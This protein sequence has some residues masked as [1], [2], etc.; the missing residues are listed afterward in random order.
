MT[1]EW[2]GVV[3]A[4]I[5]GVGAGGGPAAF[6]ANAIFAPQG[7]HVHGSSIVECPNGDLLACWFHGS[8][9][10]TATDVLVQGAR[11]RKGA[12]EWSPVF[13]MADSPGFPDC[14]P[15]LFIDKQDRLWLFWIQVLAGRWECA[16]L[17]YRRADVY[18]DDG[19]PQWNWQDAIFLKPGEAFAETMKAR[20]DEMGLEEGMWAEYALPYSRMLVEAAR[21]DRKR[22]LGWMT[23][24]HPLELASGRILLPLYSDGFNACLMAVTDDMGETWRASKPIIGLGPIQPSLVQRKNGDVVAYLRDSGALP[25]RIQVSESQDDGESWSASVDTDLLNP[26]ASIEAIALR[27]GRWLM[28]FNDSEFQRNPLTAAFSTDQGRTWPVRQNVEPA[29][30]EGRSF[31]YPSVI[32]ARDGRVHMTY[33][34]KSAAGNCIRHGILTVE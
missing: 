20:F 17:K 12:S 19:P 26:G 27:D 30:K 8:G 21:D 10:R 32:Q 6:E 3:A 18:Q 14:N 22:Q 5:C 28:V 33:T 11:L 13:V 34:H 2:L 31:G 9:E 29:D 23:R 24:I 16:V 15:V 25:G 7:K 4:V 1:G